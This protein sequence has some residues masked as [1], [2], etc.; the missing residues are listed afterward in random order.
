[1]AGGCPAIPWAP[2]D[3]R[4]PRVAM[5]ISVLLFASWADAFGARLAVELP[6][7]ARVA[8]LLHELQG[9]A[10]SRTLPAPMVAVNQRYATLDQVIQ[11][12]DEV[13]I[14]PPVAGG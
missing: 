12:G 13:A 8:D 3:A 9:R 7:G 14:V 2:A 1:M 6:P 4:P 5:T 11:L 10:A